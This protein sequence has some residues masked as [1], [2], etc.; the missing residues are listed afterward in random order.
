[1]NISIIV[2]SINTGDIMGD[3]NTKRG[4]VLGMEPNGENSIIQAQAPYSE[5]IRYAID[6]KSITQGRGSFSLEFSNYEIVP[7]HISQ[8]VI[9]EKAAEKK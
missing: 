6:L 3:L 5:L 8:K 2:P 4:R 1:M 7:P 9:E